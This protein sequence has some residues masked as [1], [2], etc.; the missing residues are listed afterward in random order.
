MNMKMTTSFEVVIN[1]FINI[2]RQRSKVI[3]G[4]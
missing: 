2:K 4:I 3:S 1:L